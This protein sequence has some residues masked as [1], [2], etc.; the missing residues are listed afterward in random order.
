[1]TP[2][3]LAEDPIPLPGTAGVG[4]DLEL[5][6]QLHRMVAT[7][8]V[9]FLILLFFGVIRRRFGTQDRIRV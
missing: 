9:V 1:M 7:L 3:K 8:D 2:A 4:F 6:A 5:V